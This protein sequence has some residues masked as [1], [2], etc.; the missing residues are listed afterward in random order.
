VLHA[1]EFYLYS[2]YILKASFQ[3]KYYA[4]PTH[5]TLSTVLKKILQAVSTSC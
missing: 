3:L 2:T 1:S 5:E 4:W